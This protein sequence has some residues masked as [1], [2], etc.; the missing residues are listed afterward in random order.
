MEDPEAIFRRIVKEQDRTLSPHFVFDT[1]ITINYEGYGY[2]TLKVLNVFNQSYLHPGMN[3]ANAG[4]YY[5]ARSTGYDS[6]ILP[7]PGRTFM[8]NLT[9]TF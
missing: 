4:N 8:I 9:L 3:S 2:F 7:Q 5:Y 6:S 1:G